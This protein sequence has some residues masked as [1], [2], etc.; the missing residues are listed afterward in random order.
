MKDPPKWIFDR[1]DMFIYEF[2][3]FLREKIQIN[4]FFEIMTNYNE[5]E[6]PFCMKV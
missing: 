5:N 4:F 3:L 2:E 6:G 1:F